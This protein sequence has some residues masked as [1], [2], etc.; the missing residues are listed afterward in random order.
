MTT[1]ATTKQARANE[2]RLL[3]SPIYGRVCD[4][5]C[6]CGVGLAPA[7]PI[8]QRPARL[9][10]GCRETTPRQHAAPPPLRVLHGS[11]LMV[12]APELR[13]QLRANRLASLA[14][15]LHLLQQ[16]LLRAR[17]LADAL[18]AAAARRGD[19]VHQARVQARVAVRGALEPR[20]PL[21]ERPQRRVRG[22]RPRTRS[23]TAAWRARRRRRASRS[24]RT[25]GCR[26]ALIRSPAFRSPG[27]PV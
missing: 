9:A 14:Q 24:R 15:Q 12:P 4:A 25:R 18:G 21:A 10:R 1:D 27:W 17:L 11:S 8:T 19:G 3:P 7:H 13:L 5:K 26:A 22:G 2:R 16:Q 23:S 6:R 20:E